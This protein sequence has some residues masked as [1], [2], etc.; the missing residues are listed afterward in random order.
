[1]TFS[2]YTKKSSADVLKEFKTSKDTG[3]SEY[4]ART[5][6][7]QY[8][9]NAVRH[10]TVT[11]IELFT[12][13]WR[14]SFIYLLIGASAL[15]LFLGQGIDAL[16]IV[17]FVLINVSLGF[18]QEYSSQK[19]LAL[20][21]SYISPKT[22]V[23]RSGS[24]TE[25]ATNAIVPGDVVPFQAG[26]MISADIRVI[27]QSDLMMD[28]S[29]LTGESQ[30]VKKQS[31]HMSTEA[32]EIFDASNICFEGTTV[33]SGSGMGVVFATGSHTAFGAMAHD[34]IN[35]IRHTSFERELNAFSRFILRLVVITLVALF[36]VNVWLKG[37]EASLGELIIFSIA[38]AV[39]VIPE[40]L[41]LVVTFCLS[42]GAH[43][44]A[45]QKVVVK[46][47]S[48]VEDLGAIDVLCTDKTGT[49][50]EN[51]L[52]VANTFA[53]KNGDPLFFCGLAV[54]RLSEHEGKRDPFDVA[55]QAALSSEKK[56]DALQYHERLSIPFDPVRRR[57]TV[58]VMRTRLATLL[59]R[60]A[61]EEIV[62]LCK[63]VS[64]SDRELCEQWIAQEGRQ[65]RRVL[66]V[67]S[68]RMT[69]KFTGSI[70]HHEHGM[71]FIG[72]ISLGDPLK[73]S[74][75]DAVLNARNLGVKVKI[76]TGD[77]F[78]VASAVAHA[79][80]LISSEEEIMTGADFDA[81]SESARRQ[82][83]EKK[84]VFVRVTPDHKL[85]I[86]QLLQSMHTVGFLGE[87]I[88]DAPAL[89]IAN[90]ALVVHGCSD[91]ARE[92]SDI[93]L[94]KKSLSV[95]VDG[96]SEGRIVFGNTL[97]YIRA[98]LA[99][100]FG[101]FYAVAVSS[102]F[103]PYLPMLPLQILL[104]NLLSDFPMI[105]IATDSVD[106][107]EIRRPAGHH[108][109]DILLIATLLGIVSTMFDFIVF[110]VFR[111]YEPSILQTNWFMTSI[112]TELAF[113]FSIRTRS[114]F[115][116]GG[117][118]SFGLLFFSV[119]A[120]ALTILLPYTSLGKSVFSFHPPSVAHLTIIFGIVG[121]YF[122][123]SESVKLMYY[124]MPSPQHT[125]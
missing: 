106:R 27:E 65:G 82:A 22:C 20:L 63:G 89:K 124:R 46:R 17:L 44:L 21:S 47:L 81:L 48:A 45:R 98:T 59:S 104:V 85:R 31:L 23:V 15:S 39:S 29:S 9:P 100:N 77:S 114:F 62:S 95:I 121:A 116:K 101:N 66:A 35:G 118:P 61:F 25:V 70:A 67:A 68:K 12:R 110:A 122:M 105:A 33:L 57:N 69:T 117:M 10:Q 72:L 53:Y 115:L 94:L 123:V 50:T 120:A 54:P 90:V 64:K 56:M 2:P 84:S 42:K 36:I 125:L 79:I 6:L 108:V 80:G 92:A 40:A 83:V 93:V 112:L 113:I 97:K 8:G 38:L 18:Y 55:I 14:S 119:L 78:A 103:I 13:Q 86:I 7:T 49:L 99:S 3:L 71:Q 76:L 58:L 24:R 87:G 1:M 88:N 75:K 60:G 43:R 111:I 109:R 41:P 91:V 16:L 26:D 74:T 96:I 51:V 11:W 5:R 32:H 30:P 28:E 102:L 52:T 19:T 4:E 107:G 73:K 37:G 34:A